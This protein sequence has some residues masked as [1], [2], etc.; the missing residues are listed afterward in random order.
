MEKFKPQDTKIISIHDDSTSIDLISCRN[1]DVYFVDK[2]QDRLVAL[3]SLNDK[4][5][6]KIS[7]YSVKNK[8]FTEYLKKIN[9]IHDKQQHIQELIKDYHVR[10]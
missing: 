1:G 9:D 10:G 3:G 6:M 5:D 2:K 7:T 8:D 4:S